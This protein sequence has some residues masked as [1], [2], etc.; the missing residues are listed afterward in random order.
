MSDEMRKTREWLEANGE[1]FTCRGTESF[2]CTELGEAIG[3]ICRMTSE[4]GETNESLV[5]RLAPFEV[6][7]WTRKEVEPFWL[8]ATADELMSTLSDDFDQ[9]YG[10]PEM[11][12]KPEKHR[13]A[14]ELL[15]RAVHA[16]VEDVGVWQCDQ[17]G[18]ITV[19]A[20]EALELL[21]VK[22]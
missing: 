7:V 9:E 19:E 18:T 4:V 2:S 5:A 8:V 16:Y 17:I 20:E 6:R 13:R 10:N 14:L 15:T 3:E 21:G 22:A 11:I 12:V 1:V